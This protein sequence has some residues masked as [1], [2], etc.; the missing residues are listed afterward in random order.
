MRTVSVRHEDVPRKWYVVDAENKVLGRLATEVATILR[1]K[2]KPIY[3]PH[4]D[5]GDY[6]IVVNAEK[7]RITGRKLVQK[8]YYRHTGY[9]GGLKSLTLEQLLEKAPERAIDALRCIIGIIMFAVPRG[10]PDERS[11]S[12]SGEGDLLHGLGHNVQEQ[13]LGPVVLRQTRPPLERHG[14]VLRIINGHQ[15]R[16]EVYRDGLERAALKLHA[17]PVVGH[18]LSFVQGQM[19]RAVGM[20]IS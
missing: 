20:C 10:G 16:L 9:P 15:D 19:H 5:T 3:T 12:R 14:G 18:G 17:L 7:I 4:I 8:R 13:H 2:H 11:R 6:I 1:G